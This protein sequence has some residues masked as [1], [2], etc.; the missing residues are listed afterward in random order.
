MLVWQL[1]HSIR[2]GGE[3]TTEGIHTALEIAETLGATWLCCAP[4]QRQLERSLSVDRYLGTDRKLRRNHAVDYDRAGAV[5]E[6]PE[7]VKCHP[8][9]V[10]NTVQV[11]RFELEGL[12]HRVQV[13]DRD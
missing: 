2:S 5:R 8:R 12:A 13:A 6:T 4:V 7:V 11:P 3:T 9:A 10:G 1:M